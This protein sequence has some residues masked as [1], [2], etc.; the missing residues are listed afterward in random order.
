M[1]FGRTAKS[2]VLLV[3]SI[4]LLGMSAA[5]RAQSTGSPVFTGEVVTLQFPESPNDPVAIVNLRQQG[6]L[7]GTGP[8][9]VSVEQIFV[10][11]QLTSGF[12][13]S[14]GTDGS[15]GQVC[16]VIGYPGFTVDART[17]IQVVL[18]AM[19]N[20][21]ERAETTIRLVNGIGPQI[22]PEDSEQI[23]SCGDEFALP[24][25]IAS[26]GDDR[27]VADSDGAPGED[28]EL[29]AVLLN[30]DP[31]NWNFTWYLE[32]SPLANGQTVTVRLPEGQHE[33]ELVVSNEIITATDTVRITVLE[34][35]APVVDAGESR[36]IPDSDGQPGEYVDLSGSATVQ[37][38][39]IES[40]R[41]Y[42]GET[43]LGEGATLRAFLPDGSHF[44]TLVATTSTGMVGM[45]TIQIAV[46]EP[47]STVL[48][49]LPGL[50]PNERRLAAKLDEACRA[51]LVDSGNNGGNGED[52][53]LAMNRR[54]VQAKIRPPTEE[55][56]ADF[57]QKCRGLLASRDTGA[58]VE[59]MG[60]LLGD[61]FAVARTQTL[62]F[63]NMQYAS[64]MDRLIALRGGSRGLSLAGLNIVVDGK[65]VPLAELQS[66][67]K[68]LLGAGASADESG[69]LLN[70]RWG[71]W[72]RGNYSFGSK[73]RDTLSP[74]FDANQYALVAGLDYRFTP[75]SVAG[76]ALAYGNSKIDFDPSDEGGL[77]T[78]SWALSVYGSFYAARNLY[79]DGIVN[80]ADSGYEARRN[81]TY[82]DGFG[83]VQA[84][85]RGDTDGLTVS[86]G[87]SGGYDF[88]I[89]GLTL[90]PNFGLFYID[91]KI[92]EF[93]E[94]GAGGL[95]LIY[96]DQKFKSLTANIGLRATFAW[97]LSWGVLLPHVRADF[98]REFEDDVEVFGI[99]FAADPNATS[100]PPILVETDNPDTSYWRL[101]AGMSAQFK[102]GVSGY[103]EYQRLE[104]FQSISFEDIS[105]GLRFQRSF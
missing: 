82:T 35:A 68:T 4:V 78:T 15:F 16:L 80:V 12:V 85:A 43:L 56:S 61:N 69:G 101:A 57:A 20:R 5:V 73:D 2:L 50:T 98:V 55:E 88:V 41:W 42:A 79:I 99:R 7:A 39:T 75:N 14:R 8:I 65:L 96:D 60:E 36:S 21:Q 58:L 19:S 94:Y 24:P 26:A 86:A 9:A 103:V 29:S 27:T 62:L 28:V 47:L 53:A 54:A 51:V 11:G 48:A 97:N 66:L 45:E 77:D 67:A 102:A 72:M 70:D 83:L 37:F 17:D 59:A 89:G 63:A 104:S 3:G 74:R 64:V 52:P 40:Y 1:P 71:L 22:D 32:G 95:N 90:S 92:D 38:G 49:E 34:P 13:G 18:T 30:Q 25:A 6:V 44:V 105:I 23:A 46:G 87:L 100:T 10:N 31:G 93:T 84:D 76:V 81:I 91:A 33:I